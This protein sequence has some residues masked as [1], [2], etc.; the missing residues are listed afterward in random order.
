M[1]TPR[2]SHVG[3]SDRVVSKK[4]RVRILS[5][6]FGSVPVENIRKEACPQSTQTSGD[7][8]F[9]VT[10]FYVLQHNTGYLTNDHHPELVK[11]ARDLRQ[12]VT[13]SSSQRRS[14]WAEGRLKHICSIQTGTLDSVQRCPF[15]SR[16]LI[17]IERPLHSLNPALIRAGTWYEWGVFR[18]QLQ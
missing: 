16:R 9:L 8:A 13:R 11:S 12:R 1:G 6:S 7:F 2:A 18:F 15:A 5:R 3:G 17:C 4:P 14:P 10:G